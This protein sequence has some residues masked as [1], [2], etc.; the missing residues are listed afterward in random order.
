[1]GRR[2]VRSAVCLGLVFA[3]P[4][5]LAASRSTKHRKTKAA[6]ADG[7][8][9]KDSIEFVR[10]KLET[11][12]NYS[13]EV[14]KTEAPPEKGKVSGTQKVSS[15]DERGC[16]LTVKR[17]I[18]LSTVVDADASHTYDE[19]SDITQK[20][21]LRDL[22]QL[23]VNMDAL[24]LTFR[25]VYQA[26]GDTSKYFQLTLEGRTS[27]TPIHHTER[28]TMRDPTAERKIQTANLNDNLAS[29]YLIISDPDVAEKVQKALT[30]SI[31]LCQ[32][33]KE[34]F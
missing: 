31:E 23:K 11:Y 1:M 6:P 16:V 8:S 9:L 25:S 13:Y 10:E 29:T 14:E 28:R 20:I 15:F 21:P 3:A 19:D 17:T 24:P 2:M 4:L 12:G 5:L 33:K 30:H 7:P 32:K 34:T 18:A 26:T 27:K 22:D